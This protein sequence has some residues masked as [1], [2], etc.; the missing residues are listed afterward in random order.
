MSCPMDIPSISSCAVNLATYILNHGRLSTWNFFK[1]NDMKEIKSQVHDFRNIVYLILNY[2]EVIRDETSKKLVCETIQDAIETSKE[3]LK[4]LGEMKSMNYAE[5]YITLRPPRFRVR[6]SLYGKRFLLLGR[7]LILTIEL[8]TVGAKSIES[9]TSDYQKANPDIPNKI[10]NHRESPSTRKYLNSR[11]ARQR[12]LNIHAIERLDNEFSFIREHLSTGYLL[13]GISR[14][15]GMAGSW[16]PYVRNIECGAR[17]RCPDGMGLAGFRRILKRMELMKQAYDDV[18]TGSSYGGGTIARASDL[19]T[20]CER[21]NECW[22]G[23]FPDGTGD[24]N[25]IHGEAPTDMY[26]LIF[27]NG[28]SVSAGNGLG[29]ASLMNANVF[30]DTAASLISS[31]C[32]WVLRQYYMSLDHQG[33]SFKLDSFEFDDGEHRLV[34]QSIPQLAKLFEQPVLPVLALAIIYTASVATV[35]YRHRHEKY[36]DSAL[37][38]GSCAAIAIGLVQGIGVR[39]IFVQL[40]PGAVAVTLLVSAV[41]HHLFVAN[42]TQ[43]QF[44][45]RGHSKPDLHGSKWAGW[46]YHNNDGTEL[47]SKQHGQNY[48]GEK[49]LV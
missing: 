32:A 30:T 35:Y 10:S 5:K 33:T 25:G 18:I 27:G 2:H 7:E 14:R 23:K 8:S 43:H 49:D 39:A 24:E 38:I 48:A 19:D 46:I 34:P 29:G 15:D 6:L 3:V 11:D 22:Y 1:E 12:Y 9:G 45:S 17:L 21:V 31:F 41:S 40:I 36:I 4:I 47:D 37:G 20:L 42:V 26:D 16:S 44:D 28:E 13:P